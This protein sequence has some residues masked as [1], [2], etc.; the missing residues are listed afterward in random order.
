M[1]TVFK[2]EEM[3]YML[4]TEQYRRLRC[5]MEPYMAVDKYGLTTIYSLYFDS[6][7]NRMIRNSIAKPIYKEKIRLRS[8]NAPVN[9]DSTVFLELKK[10]YKGTVY[11]RRTPMTLAQ[12]ENY[13]STGEKPFDS[14]IMNEI[15]HSVHLHRAAPALLMCY[16]RIALFGWEDRTLRMTF[17]FNVRCRRTELD[18][19]KGDH[20]DLITSPY[21]VLLE[22]KITGSMPLWMAQALS[23]IKAYPT[24]FSKYGAYFEME[25]QGRQNVF[26]IYPSKC[27]INS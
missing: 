25:E 23:E 20:G 17:D 22:I 16:D 4:T 15:D 27:A 24:S 10:K 2:R 5:L 7:D 13:I 18:L 19:T 21:N 3:K 6:P 14:Q 1:V 12:S 9:G 11:K 26:G 8:Y